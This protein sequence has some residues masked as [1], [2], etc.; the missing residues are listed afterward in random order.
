MRIA[1]FTDTY[2]NDVDGVARTL[3]MLAAHV[4]ECG[5]AR[6]FARRLT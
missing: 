3:G 5:R 6:S 1:L 2:P 4:V